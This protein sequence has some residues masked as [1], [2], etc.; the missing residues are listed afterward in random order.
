MHLQS[1]IFDMTINYFLTNC[2]LLFVSWSLPLQDGWSALCLAAQKGSNGAVVQ[3]LLEAGATVNHADKVGV[4]I[5]LLI[6]ETILI[7][8]NSYHTVLSVLVHLSGSFDSSLLP[9]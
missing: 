8:V 5:E 4:L 6:M 1:L 3:T 9:N 7:V 2:T